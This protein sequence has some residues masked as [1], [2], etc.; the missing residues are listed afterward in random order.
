MILSVFLALLMLLVLVKRLSGIPIRA[1]P[2]R[3]ICLSTDMEEP[4]LDV[5]RLLLFGE[6]TNCTQLGLRA[7]ASSTPTGL[8]LASHLLS[9][10]FL[11]CF[12]ILAAT[13]GYWSEQY[14]IRACRIS[15]RVLQGKVQTI[16]R[17]S[18]CAKW[19]LILLDLQLLSLDLISKV[20]KCLSKGNVI[21]TNIHIG[22]HPQIVPVVPVNPGLV[23]EAIS[24]NHGLTEE[25]LWIS[26]LGTSVGSLVSIILRLE[27]QPRLAVQKGVDNAQTMAI[28]A[29]PGIIF[30]NRKPLASPYPYHCSHNKGELLA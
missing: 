16:L 22:Q 20:S 14:S 7:G 8:A 10:R 9:R 6:F 12:G 11:V 25:L 23:R 24:T 1:I 26:R 5:E 3:I 4:V 29:R 17:I 28:I 30:H 15:Q 18:Y 21:I 2:G 27:V 19:F 13:I